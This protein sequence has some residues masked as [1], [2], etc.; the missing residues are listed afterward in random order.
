MAT[1]VVAN[2]HL[3]PRVDSVFGPNISKAM[4]VVLEGE[5]GM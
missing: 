2:P 3:T 5:Q 4:S 1:N